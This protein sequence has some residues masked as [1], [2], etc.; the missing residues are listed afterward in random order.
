[1]SG[2]TTPLAP[3]ERAALA[4]A[5]V[6]AARGLGGT[7]PNPVVG[8][9]V[10]DAAGAVVGEGW[11]ARAGDAHAEVVAL[12]AAG[13]RA[14]GGTAVV[15]LEPCDHTGRTPPCSRALL[16]AG[17]ARVVVAVPDPTPRAAGGTGTLAAAGVDVVHVPAGDDAAARRVNEA[18]L[19]AQRLGRP[20]VTWKLA[21]TLDGRSAAADGTSRWITSPESRA[22][23]HLLRARSDAV[24]VGVG[25]VLA[26]DPSLTVRDLPPTGDDV[27]DAAL[28]GRAPLRVVLDADGRTPPGA[29]VRRG[30]VPGG[31]P[32]V[33]ETLVLT[34]AD[35]GRGAGGGV[36]LAG[37]LGALH[38]R[39][40][41]A[42]MLEGGPR[43][44]G[45]FVDAGLVDRVRAYLAP[46][47]LGQGSAALVASA[48]GASM[49]AVARLAVDDVARVGPDLRVDLV[50]LG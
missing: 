2:P 33:G 32:G 23:A 5:V 29:A 40:V 26:D 11:H 24:V 15:T 13:E 27:A 44:A 35:V 46:A 14:R 30:S 12:R 37:A 47:L 8:C 34:A 21:A 4:R 16:A 9:V 42:V 48:T 39:G 36:D 49:D 7:R 17:V 50:P 18:W 31:T 20:H 3:V 6:L 45:A 28:A 10:L 38:G 25:T 1:M 19:L 41:R 22:D 43:L